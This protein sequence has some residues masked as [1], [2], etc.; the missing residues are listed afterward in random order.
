MQPRNLL[1]N[2]GQLLLIPSAM[3]LPLAI[4]SPLVVLLLAA[5]VIVSPSDPIRLSLV[6]AHSKS[7]HMK[8]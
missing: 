6:T 8:S 4:V 5:S 3:T 7:R 1:A 2:S